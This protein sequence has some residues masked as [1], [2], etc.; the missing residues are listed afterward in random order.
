MPHQL[1]VSRPNTPP[2]ISAIGTH[3]ASDTPLEFEVR[4]GETLELP[5]H[6]SD[7]EDDS[8]AF[9]LVGVPLGSRPVYVFRSTATGA[10]FWTLSEQE[11]EQSAHDLC[12]E[13][14]L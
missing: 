5:I 10:G 14:G 4:V 11:K 8:L 1:R 2:I 6:A 7:R 12:G 3:A 13:V 9:S